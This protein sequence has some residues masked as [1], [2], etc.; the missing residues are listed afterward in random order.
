[1]RDFTEAG[2]DEDNM[3]FPA[4]WYFSAAFNPATWFGIVGE[5]SGSY[6]ND[7]D[8]EYFDLQSSTDAQVYAFL[9]GPRFFKKMGRVVPFAQIL[10]GVAHLRAQVRLTPG[11]PG[12]VDT[13]EDSTTDFALQPGGGLTILLTD[14]VGVRLAGDYRSIINF[15]EEENDYT[16]EFRMIAG[17]SLQWGGR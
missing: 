2:P 7:L 13:V 5:V 12:V 11:I 6:K 15:A 3:D 9:G 17:F 4:G 10:T 16:N 8:V 14:R 1:M